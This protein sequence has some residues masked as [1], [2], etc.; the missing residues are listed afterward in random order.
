M[1]TGEHWIEMEVKRDYE[2][3]Y[4]EGDRIAFYP[5]VVY[6]KAVSDGPAGG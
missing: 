1:D 3:Y 6:A 4:L 2:G 5:K